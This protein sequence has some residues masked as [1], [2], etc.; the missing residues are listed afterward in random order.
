VVERTEDQERLGSG[1][2]RRGI[3][4]NGKGAQ[5]RP[6][7]RGKMRSRGIGWIGFFFYG[8]AA[9]T[10]VGVK[11]FGFIPSEQYFAPLEILGRFIIDPKAFIS[12]YSTI[13]ETFPTIL[14]VMTVVYFAGLISSLYGLVNGRVAYTRY[15]GVLGLLFSFLAYIS[16]IG[17]ASHVKTGFMEIWSIGTGIHVAF[18]GSVLMLYSAQR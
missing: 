14:I 11:Q 2:H 12:A 17:L 7:G 15:G 9:F 4:P 1:T 5:A 8:V 3:M 6:I 13:S 16:I 18:L 10:P